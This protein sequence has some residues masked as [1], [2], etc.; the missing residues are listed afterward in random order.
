MKVAKITHTVGIPTFTCAYEY[1]RKIQT[2][3]S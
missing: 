3:F 1:W 2:D